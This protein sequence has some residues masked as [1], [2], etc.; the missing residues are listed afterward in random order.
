MQ[1]TGYFILVQL[2][3]QNLFSGKV[4]IF[5]ICYKS[6]INIVPG[7]I[8]FPNSFFLLFWL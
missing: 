2:E 6:G 1:T 7:S 5:A 8:R 3:L 4:D